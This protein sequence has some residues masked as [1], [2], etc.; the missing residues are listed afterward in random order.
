MCYS[1]GP[2]LMLSQPAS[3]IPT[4][5]LPWL[6]PRQQISKTSV[7]FFLLPSC[8]PSNTR[9]LS[10]IKVSSSGSVT[11]EWG[12][13]CVYTTPT[14]AGSTVTVVG[15]FGYVFT[16]LI[17]PIINIF[18]QFDSNESYQL[19]H[20]SGNGGQFRLYHHHHDY[21]SPVHWSFGHF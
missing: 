14:S 9:P 1:S 3:H 19:G 13:N 12:P 17:H 20:C 4:G 5:V 11:W 16:S 8:F 6:F 15:V 2:G 18:L 10:V 7:S 21:D